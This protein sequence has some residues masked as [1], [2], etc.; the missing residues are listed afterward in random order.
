MVSL[1]KEETMIQKTKRNKSIEKRKQIV[2]P[3]DSKA[4]KNKYG[5]TISNFIKFDLPVKYNSKTGKLDI[6]NK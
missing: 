5:Y 2:K 6:I 3:E 4:T 1:A